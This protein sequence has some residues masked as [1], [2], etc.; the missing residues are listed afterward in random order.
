MCHSLH[1]SHQNNEEDNLETLCM[2]FFFA[3]F[4]LFLNACVY[5]RCTSRYVCLPN[6]FKAHQGTI[7]RP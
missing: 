4:L 3:L 6:F 2:H 1:L 5:N 7:Q